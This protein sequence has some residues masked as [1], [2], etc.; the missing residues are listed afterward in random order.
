MQWMAIVAARGT[1]ESGKY[2][3]SRGTLTRNTL[4]Q[5]GLR[6]ETRTNR[7]QFHLSRLQ[8]GVSTSPPRFRLATSECPELRGLTNT[9]LRLYS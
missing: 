9:A 1:G 7:R 2:F 4:N 8:T 3:R 6:T 5:R